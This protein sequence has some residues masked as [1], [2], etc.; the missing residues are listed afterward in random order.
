LWDELRMQ[1]P[2]FE[3]LHGHGLGVIAVGHSVSPQ[4]AALCSLYDAACVNSIRKRFCLLGER[5]ILQTQRERV[6]SEEVAPREERIRS[7]AAETTQSQVEAAKA[8][9]RAATAEALSTQLKEELYSQSS[10]SA[11][12]VRQLE[13]QLESQS[14]QSADKVRQLEKKVRQLEVQVEHVNLALREARTLSHSLSRSL[15]WRLT[16]PLRVLRDAGATALK[17]IKR[18]D[19]DSAAKPTAWRALFYPGS[20]LKAKDL[21]IWLPQANPP[22]DPSVL[23]NSFYKAAFGRLADPEGLANQIHQLHSGVSLE[24]LAEELVGLPEF[25]T[26]HGSNQKVDIKYIAA[27]YRDGLGREPD[28]EGLALWL[29]AGAKGAT[30]AKVLAA[31]A[32]SDEGIEKARASS[33]ANLSQIGDPRR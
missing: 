28:P 12:K 9:A 19:D 22:G 15:S 20:A 27:L 17:R 25:Q 3:C 30:R 32:S 10:Q 18:R 24:V 13:H 1:F 29:A 5:W 14:S 4:V 6:Q 33:S 26:R 23:V 21:D 11:D 16:W 2:S 31:L 7:L 8:M